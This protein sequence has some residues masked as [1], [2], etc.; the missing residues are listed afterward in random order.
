MTIARCLSLRAAESARPRELVSTACGPRFLLPSSARPSPISVRVLSVAS[1]SGKP[2]IPVLA[3]R[4]MTPRPMVG[5]SL[6]ATSGSTLMMT[7]QPHLGCL[8]RAQAV[9]IW[10]L[11]LTASS[12]SAISRSSSASMIL[13]TQVRVT[14]RPARRHRL[15]NGQRRRRRK[16]YDGN[17]RCGPPQG[18][19]IVPPSTPPR[20]RFPMPRCQDLGRSSVASGP[21]S[22]APSTRPRLTPGGGFAMGCGPLRH[23]MGTPRTPLN[24]P[25]LK[26]P[27]PTL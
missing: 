24:E 10:T 26:S 1:E 15:P 3:S 23:A 7:P 2:A 5:T 16:R 9:A 12:R 13:P 20:S 11:T 6:K 18:A 21:W 17:N 25:C 8:R 27:R 4:L 22:S 14:N 19:T